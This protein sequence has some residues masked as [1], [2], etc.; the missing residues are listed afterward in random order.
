VWQASH[1]AT[2]KP[3]PLAFNAWMFSSPLRPILWQPP[4][5]FMPSDKAIGK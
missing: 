5:P 1:E 2:P 4:H 3:A